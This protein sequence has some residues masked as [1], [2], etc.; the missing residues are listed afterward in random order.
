MLY[1]S[2]CTRSIELNR[3]YQDGLIDDFS[4]D[5]T[6]MIDTSTFIQALRERGVT[7]FAGVPDSLLKE[8]SGCLMHMAQSS[9]RAD[10]PR[11]IITA[12]EG[13]AVGLAI[14]HYLAAGTPAVVYMQNSGL[15][16]IVNPVCSLADPE[17]Y[18]VPMLCIIGWRGEPGVKD[19]PQHKKQGRITLLQLETLEMPYLV[20]DADSDVIAALDDIWPK[21][22]A[23][24]GPAALVIRKNSLS[25]VGYMPEKAPSGWPTGLVPL[26]REE[27][28]KA[29]IELLPDDA[30]VIATTGK[31]GR[32]LYEL[33]Q[34]AGQAQRDFLTVGG[35]G[36]ASSIA[37]GVALNQPNR[38]V[39]C[40]DG[41]GAFLMHMGAAAIIGSQT[42]PNFLHVLLNNQ[43][44][45]S[46]G[47][48]PTVGGKV[49]CRAIAFACGYKTYT[50][51]RSVGEIRAA[52]VNLSAKP[53]PHFLEIHLWK[54]AR[55]DLGR[56][57]STPAENKAAVMRHLGTAV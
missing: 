43:A 7:L 17:V 19:E 33:R 18:G 36:H 3:L 2:K 25:P 48:Q 23:S 30:C 49:D 47:G 11:H 32:E 55:K 24:N 29:L 28:V 34:A 41:D 31:T 6:I 9:E 37:L 21:M 14:G 5:E 46:V 54:G 20:L 39:V 57:A 22:L 35:M 4:R 12:N 8:F 38:Q 53:G 51:A 1:Y 10:S 13:N 52:A 45:E 15:G 42:C 56:P 50:V 26:Y 44:H 40:L 27:A 16:N